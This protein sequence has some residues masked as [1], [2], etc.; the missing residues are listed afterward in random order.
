MQSLVREVTQSIDKIIASQP[1]DRQSEL[2]E[3]KTKRNEILAEFKKIYAKKLQASKT[4]IHGNL[5]LQY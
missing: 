2:E 3:L 4:R 1:A 5:H